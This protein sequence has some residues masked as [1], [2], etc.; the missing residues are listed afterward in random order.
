M[1]QVLVLLRAH[2]SQDAAWAPRSS[3]DFE[4]GSDEQ[5]ALGGKLVEVGKAGESEFV[6]SMHSR[7]ARERWFEAKRL[8][9]VGADTFRAPADNIPMLG[10]EG[11]QLGVGAGHVRAIVS[12]IQEASRV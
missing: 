10:E 3:S 6:G 1:C 9:G 8:S 11:N 12:N 2:K 5:R 7:M 4:R